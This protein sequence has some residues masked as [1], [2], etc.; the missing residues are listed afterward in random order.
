[1]KRNAL[2]FAIFTALYFL[3][4]SNAYGQKTEV[5]QFGVITSSLEDSSPI[6]VVK[7]GEPEFNSMRDALALAINSSRY[8]FNAAMF[9]RKQDD[10]WIITEWRLPSKEDFNDEFPL[11]LQI[12]RDADEMPDWFLKLPE[13]FQKNIMGFL[14]FYS[15]AYRIY[16]DDKSEGTA[17]DLAAAINIK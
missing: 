6:F 3:S 4:I 7:I 12:K 2:L 9:I 13:K 10:S 14:A 8:S 11:N 5:E 1:M 17:L 16:L 15:G